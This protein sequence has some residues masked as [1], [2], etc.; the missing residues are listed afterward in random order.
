MKRLLR[1]ICLTGFLFGNLQAAT[2]TLEPRTQVSSNN[3]NFDLSVYPGNAKYND[4]GNG[5]AEPGAPTF[6]KVLG[7]GTV[8]SHNLVG[9]SGSGSEL[10]TY[11]SSGTR[12][13][14]P[15]RVGTTASTHGNGEDWANVWTSS[16]PGPDINFSG[17]AKDHNPTSVAGAANTFARVAEADGTIDI[18]GLSSGQ[19]YFP[20]GSFNNGWT[21]TLT[22]SGAGQ[23]DLQAVDSEGGIGNINRGWISEFSFINEGQYDSI[24][25]EWRHQDLDGS[26][27]SRARFMGVILDGTSAPAGPPEVANSAATGI[28]PSSATI[29][30]QITDT[31]NSS[32]SVTIYWGDND[33]GTTAGSWDNSV[34]LGEQTGSFS[35]GLT[36]LIPSTTYFFRCFVSNSVGSDWANSTSS[37]TTLAPPNPPTVVNGA[38][39]GVGFIE[40]DLNGA[41]TSTGG[42]VPIV[43]IYFG[44]NDGG[45]NPGVWDDAVV[46]GNEDG[47]FTTN[48]FGLTD[49]TIYYFRAYAENGGGGAWAP[50]TQTFTTM[51]FSPP[52]VTSSAAI[53]ITGTAVEI[54]GEVT[55]TGDDPPVITIYFGQNDG[56][57]SPG[58][59]NDSMDLGQQSAG[60]SAVLNGLS[61][62]TTYYYRVF[63]QN[64]AGSVWSDTTLSF[65]TLEVSELII[66]EFMAANDGGQDNNPNGWYPIA[67]QVPGTTD[68][69]IEI[70]NT[71]GSTYDL[72]GWHLTDDPADPTKWTFPSPTN[73]LPGQYLIVY[74]S[75]SGVPDANG[76]LHTNF[77][78]AS[79]GEYLAL[80]SP[81]GTPFSEFH[82]GGNFYP[83]QNDDISYGLH[84]V[85][86]DPV[87]FASPTPGAPND[88]DGLA[89]VADTNFSPD[90][91]FYQSAIDVTISSDTP[92]AVIYYTTDG[93]PPVDDTG[94]P[95][96]NA[97]T[98]TGPI[99]VTKTMPIRAAATL[100]GL[101]PT[102]IDSHTY[103]LVDIDNA[104]P[105]GTDPA[106]LNT[107]FLQ[108]TRPAGWGGGN[109]EMDTRVSQNTGLATG[110]TTTVAQ[111]MLLGLRD[112]PTMSIVM[113][114]DDF[115]GSSGIYSNAGNRSLEYPCSAEFIPIEGDSRDDWQ[116]NCGIKVFGGASRSRSP[117]HSLNLRFRTEY[118]PGKLRHPL[119]PGSEVEEFNSIAF[120]SGYNNSWI[121]W[122][123]EQR[124]RGSMIR[125]QWMR[126][127]MLDMGNPA[128]GHGF[129]VHLFINGLYWGVH[130][131]CE[132]PEA[133]HYAAHNGGD[134]EVL[135]ARNA[136]STIDGT[137]AAYDAM[138]SLISATGT[139]DY[140]QKVQGVLDIDHYIDYQIINR[141]GGNGDLSAGN[142]WRSAGGGPFPAGQPEL[143]APWQIYSWDGERTLEN[144][145]SSST[146]TD[147]VGV[148]GTLESNAEYRARFADRVN[149]HFSEGGALTPEAT[150]ARWMKYANNLDRAIIAESARWG[151][152]SGTLYTRDNHWLT[153]QSRLLNSYFPVRSNNVLSGYSSL[154]PDNDAPEFLVDGTPRKGGIFPVGGTLQLMANSGTIYYTTDGSDPR[155]E[156]GGIHP[157]A[158]SI[159]AG[160]NQ[161]SLITLE[162][163]GWQYLDTG[164]AQ[165]ASDVVN[166]HP[167]YGPSDWK[168]PQF[169]DS[170][171]KT[172][173]ALLGY[174][175]ISGRTINELI[176][177]QSPRLP[178]LY[179]RKSFEV[180]DADSF[181]EVVVSLIRDDGAIVY[182]NGRELGRSNMNG[183]NQ[184]Y[185]DF[186]IN[187]TSNEGALINLG[188]FGVN[189]GDLVEG[190]NVIAVE[191]HQSSSTSSDTGFDLQLS[192][193]APVGGGGGSEVELNGSSVV[194]A[195]AFDNGEWSALSEGRFI[196][197]PIADASN[198]VVSELMY[199]SPGQSEDTEWMELM[200]ISSSTIDLT[201]LVF[202][203]IEFEFPFGFTLEAGE[204]VVLVKNQAAFA[205][206]YN[207]AGMNIAPGEFATTSLDN[208]GER[209]SL[210]DALGVEVRSFRYNDKAPWPTGPDG[211]G[212]SLVLIDPMSSPDHDDPMSWRSSAML[213]GTP[214]GSD[215]TAFAGDP[216]LDLDGDGLSAFL[217]Y[218]FG[219]S[220]GDA[221]PSPEANLILGTVET[222]NGAGGVENYLTL[223]FRRNLAADDVSFAVE[224]SND[225]K[226]WTQP[227]LLLV[228]SIP[229]GDGTAAVTYRSVQPLGSVEREFLRVR[230]VSRR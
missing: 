96:A 142:N 217:E 219:T 69:W 140:W 58:A 60:F 182:L 144:P 206:A 195:R 7:D 134:E 51:A 207:T 120:R 76:N 20:V 43:T 218:A 169:D 33:A 79:S 109:Y 155:L 81:A 45:T 36:G 35:T 21:L 119:F 48:L 68:D 143:M 83:G 136:G 167:S 177:I 225:L 201:D 38:A 211:D 230:V 221:G 37:F 212:F 124:A 226:A 22:M 25:Y 121:H 130:N 56:G 54:G 165:S 14:T 12:T 137:T 63:A 210:V 75:G 183:G 128:A 148:R 138:K 127:S 115:A 170:S 103:I 89:Q 208:S 203:G 40:A 132:R 85:S 113:D 204:R 160:A 178:T 135:D 101:A 29:G 104:A 129:M 8:L 61:S 82:P 171:W 222:D 186:A 70:L 74:A 59:W 116:V 16:D 158:G 95:T 28:L 145:S 50:S 193:I 117:K 123:G 15:V 156:G 13:P 161:T 67:N 125:D 187:A 118:G 216:D 166:G 185:G 108:Q 106:G 97:L 26:P 19:I 47:A 65:T 24:S 214:G 149:M 196:V 228:S 90:R 77:R 39:T 4:R 66:T 49:D 223:T 112:I 73:I 107:A 162:E 172:G 32:P 147:P 198:L 105:D 229:N 86:S 72:G 94:A 34:T 93:T 184:E 224:I 99:A 92:N 146:P 202:S 227:G 9:N 80:S 88:A 18:S 3:A 41:V 188:T 176:P 168:H 42:E 215:A 164:V 191:L 192:G 194:K 220:Q 17:S 11:S 30:G 46:L 87:Y 6:Q 126:Q 141:Y 181:T 114:R 110:H 154:L 175:T 64:A 163:N 71:S 44:D 27:G 57:A 151:D 174:G 133:S 173:Q 139:P 122:S 150:A 152:S 102:N 53:N 78:L 189:P 209:I 98:Y 179:F 180:T 200:N 213:G 1:S 131:I 62:L 84:P 190:T 23:P 52:A 205:T 199:N 157:A 159:G 91:G 197:A 100:T 153:E 2:L 10:T 55:E 111:T 31:G 5:G